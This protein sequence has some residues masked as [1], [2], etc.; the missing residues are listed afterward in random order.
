MS[1]VDPAILCPGCFVA[2]LSAGVCGYCGFDPREPRP[3]SAIGLGALVGNQF[4]LGRVL[5]K[6]GGF[7]ITY[8]AFDREDGQRVALKEYMPRDLVVR[9][10]DGSTILPQSQEEGDLFRHGLGQFVREARTLA[11]LHHPNIVGVRRFLEANGTAYLAMDYYRGVS[12]AEYLGAQPDGRVPEHT[13]LALMQPVLDGLRAVHAQGFLHRDIKPANIYLAKIEG[14]GVNPILID[15][16]AARTAIGERSRSL[17]VVVTDGYAP[18]E[19]YHRRGRQGPATDLYAAGAVLYRMLTGRTPPPAPE[20][21]SR[22]TLEPASRY[23]IS[24][25]VSDAIGHA[26]Q[27]EAYQRPQ[28]VQLFQQALAGAAP[29]PP[30]RHDPPAAAF[31]SEDTADAGAGGSQRSQAFFPRLW[32][33]DFGL[34]KTFWLYLVLVSVLVGFALN[35]VES[36]PV[37]L[38]VLLLFTA[39]R[40]VAL[41]GTWRAADRFTGSKVWGVLS[42]LVVVGDVAMTLWGWVAV[43]T[44]LG[45]L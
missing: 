34:A 15:F 11:Q 27:V 2:P 5:G 25:P 29:P 40:V 19:Q 4:L 26:L 44:L 24:A 7:G 22:D 41:V 35:L 33:G 39:Y 45:E 36:L 21:M 1:P 31:R 37:L 38:L 16:G 20:R 14:G 28:T 23:G 42:K 30:V 43:L 18:F 9:A 13:A 32:R 6:P 8:L 3:P 17:S 12:L 10:A